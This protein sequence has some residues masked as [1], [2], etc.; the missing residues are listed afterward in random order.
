VI[1][2]GLTT[3]AQ[4]LT[5][6]LLPEDYLGLIN[7]LWST[8][9]LCGRIEAVNAETADAATLV[10]RSGRGWAV[11]RPGQWVRI[12]IDIQGR[13]HW[14]S[15]SL[16]SAPGRS[17]GR[18]TVTVKAMR[19]GLVSTHLVPCTAPGTTVRLSRPEGEFVL[20][21]P[22][23]RRLLFVTAGSGITPVMAMLDA[24]LDGVPSGPAGR[25]RCST[26]SRRAGPGPPIDSTSSASARSW[27]P[28]GRGTRALHQERPGDGRR[29]RDAVAGRRRER[30]G[31]HAERLPHGHLRR[32]PSRRPGPGPAHRPGAR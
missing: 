15:Y 22:P 29:R 14:R 3:A 9:D 4:W 32:A 17:D 26:T 16:S 31:S 2:R 12:G 13:R 19:G 25:R 27:Q 24:L 23:P 28:E 1:L 11:H 18:I 30:R 7:P 10:I 6:P 8:G 21:E 5:S 20:P